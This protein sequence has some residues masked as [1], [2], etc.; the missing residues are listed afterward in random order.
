MKHSSVLLGLYGNNFQ[1]GHLPFKGGQINFAPHM[2][3]HC[4]VYQN[5]NSSRLLLQRP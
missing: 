3:L 5:R 1:L 2:H 4:T